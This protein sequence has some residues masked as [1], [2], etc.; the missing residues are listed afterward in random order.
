MAKLTLKDLRTTYRTLTKL[1]EE[2]PQ[3]LLVAL[4]DKIKAEEKSR[5]Y[6]K[7]AR[8]SEEDLISYQATPKRRL[9]INLPDGRI[10]QEKT[11]EATFYT[12]LREL[13]FTS[14]LAL[15]LSHKGTP[16]FIGFKEKRKQL[17]G[18]KMLHESCF[19]YRKLKSTERIELLRK[20]DEAL[21]LNWD[22]MLI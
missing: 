5:T 12:A 21:K 11:N 6:R 16:L 7:I 22:I 17:T 8:M 19:V 1:D 20:L 3:Y 4:A 14:T 2:V 13:D 9:R 10:V 15:N 18:Y